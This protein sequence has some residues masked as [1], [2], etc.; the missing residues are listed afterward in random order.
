MFKLSIYK[1]SQLTN[2]ATFPTREELDAWLNFHLE[3]ETFGKAEQPEIKETRRILYKASE[4]IKEAV[5]DEETGEEIE[6]AEY[7]EEE[8]LDQEVTLRPYIP[9]EYTYE[10]KN[11]A[12]DY[13]YRLQQV[14]A[15][16]RSEYPPMED[17]LDAIVKNDEA[18]KQAYIDACIAVKLANPKPEPS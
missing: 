7:S 9:A 12:E 16:R 13:E 15:K 2:Q 10:I 4:L 3:H 8:W 18:Q 11:L 1:N 17:Y 5:I 6:P 14:L